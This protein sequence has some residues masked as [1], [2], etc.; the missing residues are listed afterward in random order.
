[1]KW[2]GY[3][4]ESFTREGEKVKTTRQ[5]NYQERNRALSRGNK[6]EI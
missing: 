6:G 2:M 4:R 3:S 5:G 1:M